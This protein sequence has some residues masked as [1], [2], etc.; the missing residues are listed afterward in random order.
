MESEKKHFLNVFSFLIA[1]HNIVE[2]V[3]S[4][5][6]PLQV[7]IVKYISQYLVLFSL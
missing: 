6:N 5:Y 7:N 3:F 4:V 1:L 2:L